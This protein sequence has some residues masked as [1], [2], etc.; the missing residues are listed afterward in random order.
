MTRSPFIAL[1]AAVL[2]SG[3]SWFGTVRDDPKNWTVEQHYRNAKAELDS[4]NYAGAVKAYEALESKFPFGKYAQQA[5][6]DVAYANYMDN[7]TAASVAA[8]DKFMK[9]YPNHPNVDYALY[10]KALAYFKPDLGLFGELLNLDAFER[11]PKALRESFEVFKDLVVRFPDSIYAQDSRSRMAYLVNSLAKHDVAV[12]QYYL[13]RG[14][15]IAAINRAENVMQRYP[16]A[17]A[18]EAAL[19]VVVQAYEKLGMKQMADDARRVLQKNFPNNT[20]VAQP[21]SRSTPWWK[22]W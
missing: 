21:G 15:H 8:A 11:D 14:A 18:N 7:E 2:L 5:T 19:V 22:L 20:M 3:C 9:L 16:Q 1:L 10:I 4:G 17:P 12:A 13:N 6:L